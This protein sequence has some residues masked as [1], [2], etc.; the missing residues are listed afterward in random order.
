MNILNYIGRVFYVSLILIIPAQQALSEQPG[1]ENNPAGDPYDPL[2]TVQPLPYSLS[3]NISPPVE[4]FPARYRKV[5]LNGLPMSDEKPQQK[6][7]TDE[8]P[9]ESYI[10]GMSLAL[11]H[12]TTDLYIPMPASDLSLS[13]RRNATSE[14]WIDDSSRTAYNPS[15]RPDLPFGLCWSSNLAPH[16]RISVKATTGYNGRGSAAS[17]I[18]SY[19]YE[20]YAYV[21]DND[22]TVYRYIVLNDNEANWEG[23]TNITDLLSGTLSFYALPSGNHDAD[24]L[25]NVLIYENGYLVFKKKFGL[26]LRYSQNSISSL[27]QSQI[28]DTGSRPLPPLPEQLE[29]D[30]RP[31]DRLQTPDLGSRTVQREI[32]HRL[33]EVEDKFGNKLVYSYAEGGVKP[34]QIEFIPVADIERRQVT[35]TYNNGR[36]ASITDPVGNTTTYLYSGATLTDVTKPDGSGVKYAYERVQEG[37]PTPQQLKPYKYQGAEVDTPYYYEQID[38]PQE[39]CNLAL[40]EDS[41]GRQYRFTYQPNRTFYHFAHIESLREQT[42]VSSEDYGVDDRA[43]EEYE[44]LLNY[45]GYYVVGG[46]PRWVSQVELPD[47]SLVHIQNNSEFRGVYYADSNVTYEGVLD[48]GSI[49]ENVITDAQGVSRT[50]RFGG[51]QIMETNEF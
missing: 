40:I 39:H 33:E 29:R 25:S 15:R 46:W 44:E 49:R 1:E 8:A 34:T 45:Q 26:T 36:V 43:Y 18:S 35:I 14:V 24:A 3:V 47:S 16:I 9:E 23:G 50:Y 4:A 13:V 19:R 38:T 2:L 48:T 7:E 31:I 32:Y 5:A 20:R 17:N 27:N 11:N 12:S 41:N 30:I 22:G 37:D 28:V 21:T 42:G 10:D 51:S 6:E